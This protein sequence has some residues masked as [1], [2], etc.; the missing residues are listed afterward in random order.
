MAKIIEFYRPAKLP[1][2]AT[3]VLDSQRG[4]VIEF[5]SAVKKSA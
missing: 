3:P 4:K 1:E 2:K 5:C